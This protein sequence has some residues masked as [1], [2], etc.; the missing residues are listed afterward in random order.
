MN[1]SKMKFRIIRNISI[2][3]IGYGAMGLSHGYG[4]CPS[5][6]ESIRLLKKAFEC[7]C[8]FFDTAEAYGWGENE[9]LIG[10]AFEGIRE[11]VIIATKLH[12][13]GTSDNWAKYIEEHL[14][15]S[16]KNLRTNYVD[17]YYCHRLPN[18]SQLS[19]EN[20]AKIFGDL[21][22]K[23]KIK[24]WGVS[25]ATSEEIE[26]L[27]AVT[28]LTCVQ[29]EYSMMERMY[30]NEIKTCEKLGICF[31]AFSP[32]ASGFLSG[33]YNKD[34]KYEGDDVRRVI[35]R[36]KKENVEAN[37]PLLEILKEFSKE[38]KCLWLKYLLRGC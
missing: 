23:G 21:I 37:Q 38:K 10:E 1:V 17:V 11:K 24:G 22:K 30:E 8:N 13:I 14:D 25:Q 2:S 16:L 18:S 7:G 29:N 28:P 26:K 9:R 6:E 33:K 20:L 15:A 12:L 31:V 36:F 34:T 35:T 3:A 4:A 32:M 27:N 19:L 5:H